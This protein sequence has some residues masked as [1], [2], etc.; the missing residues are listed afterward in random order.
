VI[1]HVLLAAH[2]RSN[3]T[4]AALEA[5]YA[6]A[7][8]AAIELRVALY[9]DGSTD[10]TSDA[11]SKRFP[12]V[13]LLHG[14]GNAFWARSMSLAEADVLATP[15]H[16]DDFLVWLNDDVDLDRNAFERLLDAA[17]RAP[18]AVIV[19]A[20][21]EPEDGSTSYSGFS[22][23]RWHPMRLQ[24]VQ[25]GGSLRPIDT[26][27]GNLVMV[28]AGVARA[29]GGIDGGFAHA[30][31]DIDY[32][33]RCGQLGIPVMLAP[34]TYGLCT[35]GPSRRAAGILKQWTQFIGPKGGGNYPSL[36]RF[37][38]RHSRLPLLFFVSTYAVWWVRALVRQGR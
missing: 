29:L 6:S 16:E 1:L 12:N 14:D 37:L 17:R 13:T 20:L 27:N 10:G 24:Q 9:D 32:G 23:S 22:R 2:N 18:G 15:F 30:L 8:Q 31:A 19:G 34:G 4:I 5:A 25:P 7:D 35:R 11:V 33:L 26:F 28:P 21:R 36:W 3:L 38:N